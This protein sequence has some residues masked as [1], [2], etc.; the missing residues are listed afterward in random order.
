MLA[1]YFNL[2]SELYYELFSNYMGK[3][4]KESFAHALQAMDIPFAVVKTP[5]GSVGEIVR[6]CYPTGACE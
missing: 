5:V 1:A 3:G 2:R 6:Q 4:D